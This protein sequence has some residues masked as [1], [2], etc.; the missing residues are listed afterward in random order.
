MVSLD[1]AMVSPLTTTLTIA[2]FCSGSV[3]EWLGDERKDK[4]D[5]S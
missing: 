2:K 4:R 5:G 1:S 3:G